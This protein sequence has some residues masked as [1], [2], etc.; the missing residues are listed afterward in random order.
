M[1][2]GYH[3]LQVGLRKFFQTE[4]LGN[5]ERGRSPVSQFSLDNSATPMSSNSP[6]SQSDAGSL[7]SGPLEHGHSAVGLSRYVLF[8]CL[9][10]FGAAIDLW[11]KSAVFAWRGL[12]G[13]SDIYWVIDGYFGIETAVNIGAVFGIGAGKGLVFAAISVVALV[14]ILVWLFRFRAAESAW[15]TF[16]LGCIT[17]GIIGN[18]YDRLGMWW[19]PNYPEVWSSGVRDWILWQ[20]SDQWKWPNFNI[21]DSLLVTGAV[22][23]F[24]QSIF[25]P[26]AAMLPAPDEQTSQ[27]GNS[28][29]D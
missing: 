3:R 7:S 4:T 1:A 28:D 2:R 10:V 23:L 12:P 24:V 21:A 27:K 22:M 14:A 29:E 13:E 11:S 18:L 6:P 16:A 25:F 20:A 8:G 26:P 17:G 9:A 5:G 15:L 19:Q